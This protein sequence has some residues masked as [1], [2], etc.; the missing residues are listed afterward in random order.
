MQ[1]SL[2][3]KAS[4]ASSRF[5]TSNIPDLLHKAGAQSTYQRTDMTGAA[6]HIESYVYLCVYS[7]HRYCEMGI[8]NPVHALNRSNI[9]I[10]RMMLS[11]ALKVLNLLHFTEDP[12]PNPKLV[13]M[14]KDFPKEPKEWLIALILLHHKAGL[15]QKPE[16]EKER[17]GLFVKTDDALEEIILRYEKSDLLKNITGKDVEQRLGIPEELDNLRWDITGKLYSYRPPFF[18]LPVNTEGNKRLLINSLQKVIDSDAKEEDKIVKDPSRWL[19][20]RFINLIPHLSDSAKASETKAMGSL[21][22]SHIKDSEDRR[23][24]EPPEHH[25]TAEPPDLWRHKEEYLEFLGAVCDHIEKPEDLM[26]EI[27]CLKR[28]ALLKPFGIYLDLMNNL[29]AIYMILVLKHGIK[30][31]KSG[32]LARFRGWSA[33][34][35]LQRCKT[36]EL[37]PSSDSLYLKLKEVLNAEIKKALLRERHVAMWDEF[38]TSAEKIYELFKVEAERI[39]RLSDKMRGPWREQLDKVLLPQA[40]NRE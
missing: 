18:R 23:N 25:W 34:A 35:V 28:E 19:T 17:Q 3:H 22:I 40:G 20:A 24:A 38:C 36:K 10:Y 6:E 31:Y 30:E 11:Q 16:R 33:Y 1:F 37:F 39:E 9:G 27:I 13:S 4:A 21:K 5:G 29:G 15:S 2:A 26:H 8:S 14:Q 7:A 12:F 32:A